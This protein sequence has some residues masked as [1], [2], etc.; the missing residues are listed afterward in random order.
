ML[1]TWIEFFWNIL[2]RKWGLK[3]IALIPI[4]MGVTDMYRKS[5]NRELAQIWAPIKIDQLQSAVVRESV[6]IL[7]RALSLNIWNNFVYMYIYL[8]FFYLSSASGWLAVTGVLMEKAFY[9]RIEI[10]ERFLTKFLFKELATF[11]QFS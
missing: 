9:F 8:Y 5:L 6:T 11:I 3:N 10:I 1:N 7:K 2:K 4:V